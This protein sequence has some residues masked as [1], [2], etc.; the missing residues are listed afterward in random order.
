MSLPNP[1]D[2]AATITWTTVS[3]ATTQVKYGL[4]TNF[5][6]STPLLPALVTNHAALL[7]N[8]TPGTGYYFAAYSQVGATLYVSSNFFFTTT[9]YV[10]TNDLF[11][12]TNI[13]TYTTNDLD[14]VNWTATNYDDSAWIGSGPGLLWTDVRG[15]NPGIPVPR[16]R[17]AFGPGHGL[18]VH[19]LLFPDPF[20]LYEQIVRRRIAVHR[21]Y[22]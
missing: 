19:H 16:N 9:N 21:L 4:T 1:D 8:L 5:D 22:R 15:P 12:L 20:Q 7:T 14:G 18:S 17:N 11:D 13:W 6:F 10:T 2:T 3:T